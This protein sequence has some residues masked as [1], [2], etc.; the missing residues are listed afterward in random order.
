M[1]TCFET[2]LA[3]SSKLRCRGENLI[4]PTEKFFL[5]NGILADVVTPWLEYCH[6]H[7]GDVIYSVKQFKSAESIKLHLRIILCEDFHTL[8]V[9]EIYYGQCP[10]C[11]DNAVTCAESFRNPPG[12]IQFLFDKD[13]G[14]IAGYFCFLD[15][16]ISVCSVLDSAVLHLLIVVGE[17]FC[18]VGGFS[19]EQGFQ[20]VFAESV[21]V[22][23]LLRILA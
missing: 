21:S 8:A 1:F 16:L 14:V 10:I 17:I 22:R 4:R 18:W 12:K 5:G 11:N 2:S 6:A 20:P 13:D 19:A 15:L 3:I 23:A 9:L 7:C